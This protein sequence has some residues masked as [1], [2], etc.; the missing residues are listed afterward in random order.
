MS[1]APLVAGLLGLA[2]FAAWVVPAVVVRW[3]L[4]GLE[5]RARV[6]N[7]RGR[8]V[9]LGLGAAWL[10]AALALAET[11]A[12]GSLLTWAG[13]RRAG[14]HLSAFGGFS[15]AI[16][17]LGLVAGA[18]A[19][20][21]LDDAFGD[22]RSKG[23]RGHLRELGRGRVTTG[24]LKLVGLASLSAIYAVR[25][26]G[27]RAAGDAAPPSAGRLVAWLTAAAVIALSANL[28]NLLDLRPARALKGYLLVGLPA[29]G[30]AGALVSGGRSLPAGGLGRGAVAAV[31]L[32]G[33]ALAVWRYDAG[34]RGMLGD[35]GANAAGA[36]AGYAAALG[37]PMP[38]LAVWAAVLLGLN[39]LSE[40]VSFSALIERNRL[41][42][43]LDG[44]GR[45]GIAGPGAAPSG[46]RPDRPPDAG[47]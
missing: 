13:L 23:L 21:L 7:H 32:A 25:A 47:A 3:A 6:R 35:A 1:G 8:E 22:S 27:S 17:P 11:E 4:P 29:A 40:R 10:L 26:V 38:W 12:V 16:V 46:T 37:L 19:F 30:L 9:P 33:P 2:A 18:F 43:A 20:G 44:L 24:T 28:V 15:S 5:R 39:L 36:L 41:L 42:R 34:E 45:P 14:S 31:L